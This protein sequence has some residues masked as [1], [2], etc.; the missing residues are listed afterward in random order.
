MIGVNGHIRIDLPHGLGRRIHLFL[1]NILCRMYHLPL[2][3]GKIHDVRVHNSDRPYPRSR[4]IQGCRR[5]QASGADD[6]HF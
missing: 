4:Q 3:V 1:S 6:Q 5:P 2:E